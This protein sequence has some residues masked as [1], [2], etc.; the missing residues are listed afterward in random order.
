MTICALYFF[1]CAI[2]ISNNQKRNYSSVLS[3]TLPAP[4]PNKLGQLLEFLI[5]SSSLIASSNFHPLPHVIIYFCNFMR[6]FYK[7]ARLDFTYFKINY[8]PKFCCRYYATKT[9]LT[10]HLFYRNR[11]LNEVYCH[12]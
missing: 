8:K 6:Q 4:H 11:F 7:E 10:S 5:L 9:I 1:K 3:E 2:F 12:M